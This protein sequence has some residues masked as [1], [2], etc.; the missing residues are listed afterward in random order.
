MKLKNRILLS[1]VEIQIEFIKNCPNTIANK[2]NNV[3]FKPKLYSAY[4]KQ[5]FVNNL[6]FDKTMKVPRL[7]A[8]KPVI[9]NKPSMHKFN[10]II[11]PAMSVRKSCC[12]KFLIKINHLLG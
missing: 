5:N 2:I 8:V 4:H 1:K 12:L 3:H 11:K 7:E 10:I 9:I 6:Y